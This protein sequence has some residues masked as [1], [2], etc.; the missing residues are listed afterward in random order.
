[1]TVHEI[2]QAT[3]EWRFYKQAVR[4]VLTGDLAQRSGQNSVDGRFC[5]KRTVRTVWTDDSAKSKRSEQCGRTILHKASG[6]NSV[7]WRF[8][9]KQAFRI[10]PG[11]CG[12]MILYKAG[13][14]GWW[15]CTKHVS[16]TGS[17][18]R[19]HKAG[20]RVFLCNYQCRQL[21]FTGP[22]GKSPVHT[23]WTVFFHSNCYRETARVCLF[24]YSFV[25]CSSN[26]WGAVKNGRGTWHIWLLFS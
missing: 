6:Q 19:A 4:T 3:L 14:Q 8:C 5:T 17:T 24:V 15:G 9:K 7:D 11:L 20:C 1:M 26:T 25:C 18:G 16:M 23:R 22:L 12:L 2:R 21:W 10:R 13:G